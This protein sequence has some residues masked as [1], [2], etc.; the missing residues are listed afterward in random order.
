MKA[1]IYG[2]GS[3]GTVLGAYLSKAGVDIELVN[4]NVTH[5]QALNKYGAR[6]TGKTEITQKVTA[7]TPDQMKGPYDIFILM[8]KQSENKTTAAF[9]KP[10]L[11]ENGIICTAQNGLPEP[12]ISEI[13]GDNRV[14]GCVVVWGATLVSPGVANLTSDPDSMNF[15]IGCLPPGMDRQIQAVKKL[16]EHMCPVAVEE[17]FLG[18]R[19]SK[20]L[21]NSAFSGLSVVF[22]L[23]FGEVSDN[24]YT[25]KIAQRVIKE[26]ID[27]AKAADIKLASVQG[28][29]IE[30]LMYYRG[31][32]KKMI[33]YNII[34][35]AISHH[36][37]IRSGMLG[38]IERGR[39]TEIDYINGVI[40]DYGKKYVC[41]TPF[42]NRI[43]EIV[44]DI[45]AKKH[46]PSLDNVRLFEDLL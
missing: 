8:T 7:I 9:L 34:P 40:C 30:K 25:R 33:A 15:Q 17:N 42:N 39:K 19:W 12:L 44:H 21:I 16:L 35:A 14:V 26:C 32:V 23:L 10:L 37:N 29:S 18:A 24:K 2:A 6:I 27:V 4:R 41:G 5:V 13:V 28:K 11:C 45:E 31:P 43:V 36:R 22:G 3:L 38:D 1:A 20:L 46:S